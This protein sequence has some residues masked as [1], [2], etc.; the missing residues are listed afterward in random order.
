AARDGGSCFWG[1]RMLT[2][3]WTGLSLAAGL[4]LLY[5]GASAQDKVAPKDGL[6]I[7]VPNALKDSDVAKIKTR[8]TDS[9][10]QDGRKGIATINFDFNPNGLPNSTAEFG[11]CN[12]LRKVIGNARSGAYGRP[13]K[14][15][16]FVSGEVSKHSV[17]PVLACS[18]LVMA[19][20]PD[21]KR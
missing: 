10:K 7:N 16:A 11:A 13:I 14:A 21:N 9:L 19:N 5:G 6:Y 18:E 4:L 1:I 2:T 20:D 17:L 12:A 8:I 15:V 3:R